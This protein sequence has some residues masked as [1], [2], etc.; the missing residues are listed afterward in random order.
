MKFRQLTTIIAFCAFW[1]TTTL[2]GPPLVCHTFDIG[3]AKSLPWI[4][5][6]WNLSGTES[7]YTKNLPADTVAI[8]NSDSTVLV[9][10]ETLRRAALYGMKDPAA[11][12]QLVLKLIAR[13]D[14]ATQNSPAAG[15]AGFDLGYFAEILTQI[16]WIAKDFANPAQNLDGYALVRKALQLRPNDAQINFAAA[17]ITLEGHVSDHPQYAQ[18]AL[19]GAS[20]DAVLARNLSVRFMGPQ[21]ETMAEMLTRKASMKTAH[22]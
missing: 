10:M 15:M 5:H 16:H 4:S 18:A 7:Y 20:S 8:L 2:A 14:G 11:L 17:L 1:A 21:S 19:A 3:N 22:R 13:S 9:H 12:K 6:S